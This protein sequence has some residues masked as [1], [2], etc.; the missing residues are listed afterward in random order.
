TSYHPNWVVWQKPQRDS[1]GRWFAGFTRW[2]SVAVRAPL[3]TGNWVEWDCGCEIMRFDNIDEGPPP[4]ELTVSYPQL[5]NGQLRIPSPF[6][7][8]ISVAQE[9]SFVVLPD[10][11]LFVTMRSFSG[12]VWYSVSEDDGDTWRTPEKLRFTDAGEAL[13]QPLCCCPI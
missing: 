4:E 2:T 11:R 6:G 3:P 13:L 12:H 8:A 10:G 7:D 9:P 5:H 1:K